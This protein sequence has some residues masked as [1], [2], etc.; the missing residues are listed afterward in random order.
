MI[1]VVI[2]LYIIGMFLQMWAI[3]LSFAAHLQEKDGDLKK[4]H[5]SSFVVMTFAVACYLIGTLL[6][7][8]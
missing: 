7:T 2:G 4:Y 3:N 6:L 8:V 5:I 1:F